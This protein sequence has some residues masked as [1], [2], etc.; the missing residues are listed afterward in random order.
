MISN[1]YKIFTLLNSK[2]KKRIFFLQILIILSSFI[3]LLSLSSTLL[4]INFIS[5]KNAIST[6]DIILNFY[7]FLEK[8]FDLPIIISLTILTL[9]ILF[10][11]IFFNVIKTYFTT[12]ISLKTGG[13]LSLSLLN[14]YLKKNLLYHLDNS[15][16]RLTSN[17]YNRVGIINSSILEPS[18]Q[19][20]DKLVLIIPL[21][22][23][24][25]SY[26]P[27][28][29]L[30]VILMFIFLYLFFYKFFRT[31]IK[32][33]GEIIASI[34]E[35]KYKLFNE[36][37]GGIKEVKLLNKYIFFKTIFGK[38][39]KAEVEA[40]TVLT[41]LGYVPKYLIE[42]VSFVF[43]IIFSFI[44]LNNFF[45]NFND[46]VIMLTVTL[47]IIYK[48]LPSFQQI[49]F[50][51]S[52]IE[53]GMPAFLELENDLTDIKNDISVESVNQLLDINKFKNFNKI[54][55]NDV[56][57][58]YNKNLLLPAIN[59]NLEIEASTT[60]GI[61]GLSGSGKST[62][63]YLL[64]GLI[65]PQKGA[66]FV[67]NEKIDSTNRQI[68][69]SNI[70]Y[71][72]QSIYI[73]ERTIAE[74]IAFGVPEKDI[75]IKNLNFA[76]KM[77]NLDEVIYNLKNGYRSKIGEKGGLSGGQLQRIG[78]AR[79]LY[80]NPKL[81][82]FDEATNALDGLT[83]NEIIHSIKYLSKNR[84]IIIIAHRLKT[85]ENCEKIIFL[86]KGFVSGFDNY[87]NLIKNNV[88]FKKL[89]DISQIS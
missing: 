50:N 37:F 89:T 28:I 76:I 63:I 27:K 74:N 43:L 64:L 49:Y 81:L 36:S 86:Q 80:T 17:L 82:I 45:Y 41:L 79:A 12:R 26:N 47:L 70:G 40:G 65:T 25:L 9:L 10:F 87:K 23:L 3:E 7:L 6:P 21:I 69:Q 88:D 24:S 59:I 33:K 85:I 71:V 13:E 83:E 44:L 32:S 84:T 16:S 1:L 30:V 38:I 60:I 57:F 78:I 62:L 8:I 53:S 31:I 29:S 51:I 20:I 73:S 19:I 55:F 11:N 22:L 2:Q 48:L 68:W 15:T 52:R 54:K 58:S 77:A 46:V 75:N 42:F 14:Y 18:L 5:G 35:A 66:L 72:P 4:Y 67:D 56:Q 39:N 61:T 34:A